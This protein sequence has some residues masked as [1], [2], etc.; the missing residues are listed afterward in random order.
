MSAQVMNVL[1][2]L[3]KNGQTI[4]MVTHE[5]EFASMADRIVRVKDGKI[6]SDEMLKKKI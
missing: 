3:N 5:E 1:L 2:E 6:V 4:V